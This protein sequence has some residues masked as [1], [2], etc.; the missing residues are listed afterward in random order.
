M[1]LWTYVGKNV[2]IEL[3]NGQQFTGKADDYDD[4]MDN[5]SGE[6]SINLYDGICLYD[7]NESE[8]KS[9]EILD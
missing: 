2:R 3:K 4:E 8:I 7:F 5:E 1:K 9:I 6:D